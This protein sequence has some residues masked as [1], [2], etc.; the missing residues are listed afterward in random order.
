MKPDEVEDIPQAPKPIKKPD[1]DI[2]T[3]RIHCWRIK[4]DFRK[5][6]KNGALYLGRTNLYGLWNRL[7]YWLFRI[8]TCKTFRHYSL[9]DKED[10]QST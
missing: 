5:L 6:Y 4:Y 9:S 3:D 1:P 7:M 2:A 10:Y 8:F